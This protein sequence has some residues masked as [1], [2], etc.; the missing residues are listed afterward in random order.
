MRRCTTRTY[1][2]PDAYKRA[3]TKSS[4][5]GHSALVSPSRSTCDGVST[6]WYRK[7]YYLNYLSG[8]SAVFW[9]QSLT[10]QFML[11]GP[12]TPH[13]PAVSTPSTS[14]SVKP[15]SDKA[16]APAFA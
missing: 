4:R 2:S 3:S 16:A 12:G 9:E 8:A 1:A 15:A 10:N 13:P 5:T 7:L 14:P 6:C 11:P